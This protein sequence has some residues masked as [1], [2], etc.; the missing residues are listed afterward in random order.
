MRLLQRFVRQRCQLLSRRQ[1]KERRNRHCAASYKYRYEPADPCIPNKSPVRP[2]VGVKNAARIESPIEKRHDGGDNKT[3]GGPKQYGAY[4]VFL[5]HQEHLVGF[6]ALP[7][8]LAELPD[9]SD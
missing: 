4:P 2:K 6:P 8:G 9:R 3:N 7:N 5:R 1:P